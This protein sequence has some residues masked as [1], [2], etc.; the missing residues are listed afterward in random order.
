MAL[1][2]FVPGLPPFWLVLLDNIGL[3]ALVAIGLV[4][5]TG[6]GGLTSFGQAA[7]CGFGAYTTAVLTTHYGW[8]PWLTLPASL[9]V[10]GGAAVL[11]GLDHCAALRPLPAAR[12]HRLGHQPLLHLRQGRDARPQRRHFRNSAAG[13]RFGAL[14]RS[15]RDLLHHL[16]RRDRRRRADHEPAGFAHRPRRPRVAARACGGRSVR[17]ADGADEAAGVHSRGGAGR[18]VRL[19]LRAF[20]ARS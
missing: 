8:S 1:I 11:L 15:A 2:P 4:I 6:V 12:H 7:F 20:P 9:L 10:S 19:A 5:L 18:P 14:R 17:R 3:A 16:V 13:D